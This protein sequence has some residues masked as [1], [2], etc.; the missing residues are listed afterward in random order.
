MS[1]IEELQKRLL[2]IKVKT[3][4]EFIEGKLNKAGEKKEDKS[5][6]E[7]KPVANLDKEAILAEIK[8]TTEEMEEATLLNPSLTTFKENMHL[9][10]ISSLALKR[11]KL[12]REYSKK[13]GRV[14]V[15]ARMVEDLFLIGELISHLAFEGDE[16]AEKMLKR[17]RSLG[18]TG[19]KVYKRNKS[20]NT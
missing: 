5:K 19:E 2:K 11:A 7:V 14:V 13:E 12:E 6:K 15:A 9:S 16:E 10:E 4:D 1:G 3:D 8:S 18:V 17:I 20:K